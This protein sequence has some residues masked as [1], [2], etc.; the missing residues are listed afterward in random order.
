LKDVQP[1]ERLQT[2]KALAHL[3]VGYLPSKFFANLDLFQAQNLRIK[4]AYML[5]LVSLKGMMRR[6]TLPPHKPG[7]LMAGQNQ[8]TDSVRMV[9]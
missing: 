7:N 1:H 9:E 4:V 5:D 6:K 3:H 2:V 8:K